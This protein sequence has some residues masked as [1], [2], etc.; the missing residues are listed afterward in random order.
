MGV[1]PVLEHRTA[2]TSF[3]FPL[4]PSGVVIHPILNKDAEWDESPSG[5]AF[6][7]PVIG[8]GARQSNHVKDIPHLKKATS[9]KI[10]P[11]LILCECGR[12]L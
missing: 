9:S 2:K 12:T 4:S 7:S 6:H 5:D 1:S 3:E 10:K 8:Q 11:C